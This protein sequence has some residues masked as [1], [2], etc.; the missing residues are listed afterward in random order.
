MN[1]SLSAN[2]VGRNAYEVSKTWK[3]GFHAFSTEHL[4]TI[5][6][7]YL[8]NKRG[9]YYVEITKDRKVYDTSA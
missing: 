9:T 4:R 2:R 5:R 3:L 8:R 7:C 6:L 1:I